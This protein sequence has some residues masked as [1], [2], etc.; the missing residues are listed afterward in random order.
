MKLA[1]FRA[2]LS[3][4]AALVAVCSSRAEA[5]APRMIH[6]TGSDYEFQ[7]PDTVPAGPATIHFTFTTEANEW[8][9]AQLVRLEDGKTIADFGGAFASQGPPP[10]W[11]AWVGG[12]NSP[13]VAGA[14]NATVV[15]RPGRYLWLCIIPSAD[16]KLHVTKGMAREMVVIGAAGG[17]LP[18]P[19][20]VV[21]LTDYDFNVTKPLTAGRQ[22]IRI[23]NTS[24][25][26]HEALIVQLMPGKTAED[27][28]KW[29]EA[30]GGPPPAKG[31]GGVVAL[32]N[33][34]ANNIEVT[35]EPGRYALICF[36][37][38]SKDGRPHFL[39]GMIKEFEVM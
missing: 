4:A 1:L 28:A 11:V 12:P 36:L 33:G 5:Q 35:L 30:P 2:P 14:S 26:F 25:Q 37:P 17:S 15:L 29:A 16:G 23:R 7:A 38:S 13:D 19:D 39:H 18:T 6:V 31:V 32:D 8:H 27:F 21:L 3:L 24:G 20:N 9:H 22:V 34:Q 10:S